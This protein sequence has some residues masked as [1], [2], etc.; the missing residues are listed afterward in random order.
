MRRLITADPCWTQERRA[1]T[2]RREAREVPR[3]LC[4]A[5]DPCTSENGPPVAI[6]RS[7]I[8]M[9][10]QRQRC[11]YEEWVAARWMLHQ[12]LSSLMSR[13]SIAAGNETFK[14]LWHQVL[15]LFSSRVH[16]SNNQLNICITLLRNI[17][18][19]PLP[20]VPSSMSSG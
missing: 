1:R 18:A 4:V 2:A 6:Q 9:H 13:M 3:A 8:V 19:P 7:E 11:G 14:V 12:L 5:T 16:S 20:N 17:F 10:H 15:A